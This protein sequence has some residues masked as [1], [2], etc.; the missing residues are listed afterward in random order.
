MSK[1]LTTTGN[2]EDIK[3]IIRNPNS[4]ETDN[5]MTKKEKDKQTNNGRQNVT[6]NNNTD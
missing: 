2:F 6:Q 4:K 1:T 3:E 5:E